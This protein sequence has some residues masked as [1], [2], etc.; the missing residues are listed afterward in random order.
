VCP[1]VSCAVLGCATTAGG[2]QPLQLPA[3]CLSHHEVV[4]AG[5]VCA[6]VW[7]KERGL[8]WV[9][10]PRQCHQTSSAS[11]CV[12]CS[13]PRPCAGATASVAS[14][15]FRALT[16]AV[17]SVGRQ[18]HLARTWQGCCGPSR[19]Q[20]LLG[21]WTGGRSMWGHGFSACCW[22]CCHTPYIV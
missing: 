17:G 8:G 14:A 1:V 22:L 20:A 6:C 2:M 18:R 19:L 5:R 9:A 11:G 10:N 7:R 3:V 13:G 12:V 15:W 16:G 4:C 21:T